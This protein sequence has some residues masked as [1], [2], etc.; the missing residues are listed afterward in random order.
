[1]RRPDL[2]SKMDADGIHIVGAGGIGCAVGY[3]LRSADVS[4]TMVDKNPRKVEWGRQHGIAVDQRNPLPANFVPFAEWQPAADSVVLLCTKCYDNAAVLERLPRSAKL[5]P[6]Q[7][8]F[9]PA[10]E[11]WNH[12]LEGIASF[13]SEWQSD[14]AHT[15]ITRQGE[16][17]IAP[18]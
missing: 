12:V 13:V 4:V 14:K 7:N 16:V 17:H 3:A 2:A 6:I 1:M 18:R 5:I 10:L 15:R 8:G 9:E 11:R